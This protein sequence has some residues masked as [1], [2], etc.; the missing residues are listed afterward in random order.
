MSIDQLRQI[1]VDYVCLSV[2]FQ[3]VPNAD[4]RYLVERQGASATFFE[5]QL[6]GGIPYV[7]TASGN[8]YRWL[9]FYNTETG[10]MDMTPF[11]SG[12]LLW[13]TACSGTACWGWQR[14]INSAKCGWTA[15]MT[16]KNGFVRV[17]NY[18]Y[19]D[20][21]NRFGDGTANDCSDIAQAN[22]A[23]VMYESYALAKKAD[24]L[25]N[26]GHVR[27]IKEDPV[28]VRNEDGT[29]NPKESYII[30][31]EQGLYTTSETHDRYTSDGNKYKIQGNDNYKAT[32]A[33]LYKDGYLPHTFKEFLGTDPVEPGIA[34]IEHTAP[35][36]S[37]TDLQKCTLKANYA[38]SHVITT[39]RDKDGN[40]LI[41][42]IK[43]T[44]NH[45]TKQMT[46]LEC[47]PGTA[48]QQHQAAGTNTIEM[49]CQLS[50]GE[51]ITFDSGTLQG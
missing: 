34:T 14:V 4:V 23:Q 6:Y 42:Y 38:L 25:V 19:D 32:F 43:Y 27:M 48:V 17:G 2:T 10:I 35:T 47:L 31:C 16:V 24:C 20:S 21:I 12:N 30:Q 46:L 45:F 3:W 50:N 8:M 1:C 39:I 13:G 40:Q 37:N 11:R 26:N 36:A 7:N 28:I 15:D 5:G 29:I 51:M 33:T 44:G 9:E 18:T 49:Q 22:G 41:R